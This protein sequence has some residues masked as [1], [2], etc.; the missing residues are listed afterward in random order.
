MATT[1]KGNA[2]LLKAMH[3][4]SRFGDAKHDKHRKRQA[5]LAGF[6]FAAGIEKVRLSFSPLLWLKCR[7]LTFIIFC[8]AD[9]TH[10][11]R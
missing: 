9:S 7:R 2:A 8:Y 3:V 4:L 5:E 11:G 10:Y 6:S 1:N